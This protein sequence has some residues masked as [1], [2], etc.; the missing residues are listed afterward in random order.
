MTKTDSLDTKELEL[1]DTTFVRD[2][3]SRVFQAIALKCLSKIEGV[4]LLES[5]LI[6][7]LL[8]RDTAERIRGI[9][10]EQDEDNHSVYIRI[11]VNILYGISI[12][13]KSEEIQSKIVEEM[14]SLTGVHVSCVHVIFKN[15]ISKPII[16]Q[17]EPK[18]LEE[19]T[20]DIGDGF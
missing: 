15:L 13:E 4:Y 18:E 5:N 16:K 7:N 12:P 2:I 1:P 19:E 3:E 6:D 9:H 17:E 10:V 20:A 11:E 14:S 8:G